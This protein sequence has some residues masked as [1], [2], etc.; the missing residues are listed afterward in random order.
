V[1]GGKSA[2]E[3]QL[4]MLFAKQLQSQA[5]KRQK[6]QLPSHNQTVPTLVKSTV[7]DTEV[8]GLLTTGMS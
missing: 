3:P 5:I 6:P 7:M 1:Q 2:C 8:I 4:A